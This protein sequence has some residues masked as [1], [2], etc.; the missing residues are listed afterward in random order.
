MVD[1]YTTYNIIYLKN[2]CGKKRLFYST[3]SLK[4]E[5]SMVRCRGF[6]SDKETEEIQTEIEIVSIPI[7]NIDYI[8]TLKVV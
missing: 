7:N 3:T 8:K 2:D 1:T 6:W 4:N 5:Y